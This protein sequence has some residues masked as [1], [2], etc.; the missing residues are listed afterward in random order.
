MNSYFEMLYL[1]SGIR[2]PRKRYA[3]N[4]SL[5]ETV[6]PTVLVKK[7]LTGG[8]FGGLTPIEYRACFYACIEQTSGRSLFFCCLEKMF[9]KSPTKGE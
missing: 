7:L 6:R 3:S 1:P 4:G 5:L 2:S 8:D 9:T